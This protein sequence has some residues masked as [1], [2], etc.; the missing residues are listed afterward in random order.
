MDNVVVNRGKVVT[1]TSLPPFSIALDG[2]VQG[3]EVD[4]DNHR[5]SFDHHAKCLRYCTTS[6][7]MQAWT[8]VLLGIEDLEKYTIYCNDVDVDVCAAV[9]CLK[10]PERCKEP[11]VKKLIDAIGLGD[12]HGGAFGYNGMSKVVEWICEPET[13]SKRHDDYHKISDDGLKS[14]LEA[15]LY[16]M[17]SYVDGE[18]AIEVSKQPKH[19]EYKILRNENDW[20][21]V[22]SQDPHAF[23][24]VYQ[25]GFSRIVLVRPQS[26]GSLAVSLAK[27]SD[28]VDKFPITKFYE[29]LN[30]EEKIIQAEMN[31]TRDAH[32]QLDGDW[33]GGST[34]GG[35]PRNRDGSR[36]YLSIPVITNQ[37]DKGIALEKG[38]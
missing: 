34:I 35:A 28:F 29:L 11:L 23:S 16:R 4:P 30:Q 15:V 5:F 12:M 10:N 27:K 32:H 31:K 7:C 36:S 18:S 22:E 33:A 21:L 24:A 19:G 2:F 8:A 20:V 3:P 17:D 13:N 14:I 25:A 26:D 38:E 6:A 37:I 9:W 1:L